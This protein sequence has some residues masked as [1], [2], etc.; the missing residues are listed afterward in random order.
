MFVIFDT[1]NRH[2]VHAKLMIDICDHV[3]IVAQFSYEYSFFIDLQNIKFIYHRQM[4]MKIGYILEQR[5]L[6][7]QTLKVKIFTSLQQTT[8]YKL[9]LGQYPTLK[10]DQQ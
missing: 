8:L 7:I 5:H 4:N 6:V 3:C 2:L 9:Y 10:F 1:P